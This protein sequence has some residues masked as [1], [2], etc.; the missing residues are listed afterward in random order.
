VEV[1]PGLPLA[2]PT[3]EWSRRSFGDLQVPTVALPAEV[4][5]VDGG[6]LKGR[7]FVPALAHYHGGAMRAQEWMNETSDFF[8]FLPDAAPAPVLLNRLEILVVT[9]PAFADAG[10]LPPE[11]RLPER[12]VA[13]DCGGRRFEGTLIIDMPDD[14]ARV[15]DYLNRPERFLTLRDGDRHHLVQKKRITRVLET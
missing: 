12:H 6:T 14:H 5:T 10:E 13:V 9:V 4:V 15:L 11:A 3:P 2:P 8:P 7:I 1:E